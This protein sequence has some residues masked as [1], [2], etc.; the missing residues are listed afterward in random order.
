MNKLYILLIAAF[1]IASI[2]Q[3]I[4]AQSEQAD[5][6]DVGIDFAPP[7]LSAFALLGVSPNEVTRPGSVK[8]LALAILNIS[9][10]GGAIAPDIAIEWSPARSFLSNNLESYKKNSLLRN[11]L[12]TIGTAKDSLGASLAFG[13]RWVP[14]DKSDPLYDAEL[15]SEIE[16]NFKLWNTIGL[17]V[18]MKDAF[19]SKRVLPLLKNITTNPETLIL[20]MNILHPD[21]SQEKHAAPQPLTDRAAYLRLIDTMN[22]NGIYTDSLSEKTLSE[23]RLVS[24][25]Y[26]D[27]INLD[28][29]VS[30]LVAQRVKNSK[31]AF[32]ARAW[33]ASVLHIASGA[34]WHSGNSTWESLKTELWRSYAGTAIGL[35]KRGQLIGQVSFDLYLQ[36][37]A[38]YDWGAA[39]GM[40]MILGG[41]DYRA[42]CEGL[43]YKLTGSESQDDESYWRYTIGGEIKLNSNLWLEL[44]LATEMPDDDFGSGKIFSLAN[45]KYAFN[46]EALIEIP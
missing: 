38:I 7:D 37:Q 24:A 15:E 26:I 46:K 27:L 29:N 45:I 13:V 5:T 10:D 33:N 36:E 17:S 35:G 16:T 32:K 30:E 44:G 40:R 1:L 39:F 43:Y 21:T 41:S 2:P 8:E 34:V 22:E 9:G 6:V 42:T 18:D 23:L 12:L 4:Y 25:E 3:A 14:I 11:L 20:L 28:F 19:I 31:A